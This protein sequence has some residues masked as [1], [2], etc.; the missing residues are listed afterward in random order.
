MF[1]TG[2][3]LLGKIQLPH[4]SKLESLG[5]TRMILSLFFLTFSLYMGTGLF[6]RPIHGMIYSYLPPSLE[7]EFSALDE[8]NNTEGS[9]GEKGMTFD[10]AL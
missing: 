3:Y 6:G 8:D 4:D 5:V 2:L 10:E 9:K 1:F 7:K